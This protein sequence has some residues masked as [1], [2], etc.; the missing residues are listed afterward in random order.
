MRCGTDFSEAL[1][2]GMLLKTERRKVYA[3]A[4]NLGLCQDTDTTNTINLHL[5]VRVT[6]GIAK[7]RQMRPPG[8][9][10]GIALHNDG[11]FVE[12]IGEGQ[13]SL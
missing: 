9:V 10:L 5:H 8:G 13:G 11:V 2:L 6:I 4:E 7:V 12:R 3:V 1:R